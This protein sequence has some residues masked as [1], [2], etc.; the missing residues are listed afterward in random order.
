MCVSIGRVASIE[1]VTERG[2]VASIMLLPKIVEI[3]LNC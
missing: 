3:G 2:I 1:T